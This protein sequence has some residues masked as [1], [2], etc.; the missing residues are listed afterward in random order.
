MF[1]FRSDFNLPFSNQRWF[2]Q[3]S[4]VFALGVCCLGFVLGD[5]VTGIEA[6]ASLEDPDHPERIYYQPPDTQENSDPQDRPRGGGSRPPCSESEMSPAPCADLELTALVPFPEI[7]KDDSQ[8]SAAKQPA[9]WG[10][11]IA[12]IP[13]FWYYI[14]YPATAI[15]SAEFELL[16][17]NDNLIF[18]DPSVQLAET[19]G[20]IGYHP[21][22]EAP[23]EVGKTYNWHLILHIDP[24]NPSLDEYVSG[25]IQRVALPPEQVAQLDTLSPLQQAD[26]LAE[27]GIWYDTLTALAKVYQDAPTAWISLLK[28]VELDEIAEEPIVNGCLYNQFPTSTYGAQ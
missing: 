11:T 22:L 9:A 21:N 7:V 28:Q 2:R 20:V 19:P 16:D 1:F 27:A 10:R 6:T 13:A 17:D 4:S 23:L 3:S 24:D 26:L 15:H 8:G 14:P 25:R 5:L 12:E 18:R